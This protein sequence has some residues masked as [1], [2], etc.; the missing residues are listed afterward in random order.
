[1]SSTYTFTPYKRQKHPHYE[2]R[3]IK[4][5]RKDNQFS[6][7]KFH[8]I[9]KVSTHKKILKSFGR[10][11][12]CL[13]E[14]AITCIPKEDLEKVCFVIVNDF[15]KDLDV[16]P[17]NDGYLVSLKHYRQAFKVFY[18][19]NSRFKEFEDYLCYF[20]KNTTTG[21]TVYYSGRNVYGEG[22]KFIDGITTK[23]TVGDIISNYSNQKC[24]VIFISDT[25]GGGSVFD[26]TGGK[27]V[28]SY[29]V[30]K[31]NPGESKK[32]KRSHG[33]FTYYFCKITSENTN[34]SPNELVQQINNLLS[35]FNEVIVCEMT[36]KKMNFEPIYS[37]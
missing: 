14:K 6:S 9:R 12:M 24:R 30:N 7:K 31:E 28:M 19:Y 20:L 17:L 5:D 3:T 22:I 27:N 35:R 37:H 25:I 18:L 8:H 2:H 32:N 33:I 15:D 36:D 21:L 11:G 4:L 16:G 10:I 13:N 23:K 29:S 34:V 26:I 1:M